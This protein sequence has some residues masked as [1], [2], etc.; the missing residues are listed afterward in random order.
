MLVTPPVA[1]RMMGVER[2]ERLGAL[3]LGSIVV[4]PL[5]FVFVWEDVFAG[6]KLFALVLV[7]GGC[8]IAVVTKRRA[9]ERALTLVPSV[10]VPLTLLLAL[11]TAA[12][13]L[14]VDLVQS[15]LGERLQ[16]QGYLAF[17][18]YVAFFLVARVSLSTLRRLQV[19]YLTVASVA[20]IVA[21]YAI[22]QRLG[23]DPVWT[24][25]PDGRVFSTIGQPNALGAFFVMTVPLTLAAAPRAAGT[26]TR[27]LLGAAVAGQLL[28]LLLTASRAALV[29]L[30]AALV[31]LAPV[32]WRWRRHHGH[33]ASVGLIAAL[34]VCAAVVAW[35]A[36]SA[37]SL[38]VQRLGASID[39]ATP[40]SVRMHLDL[41]AVAVRVAADHPVFG[42]GPDTY[43]VVFPAYRDRVLPEQQ[44]DAFV[45]YRVESPHNV[46]L[47]TASGSGIPAALTYTWI[48]GVVIWL[49]LRARREGEHL[50]ERVMRYGL[51]AAIVGHFVTDVFMTAEVTSSWLF[52]IL[53]GGGVGFTTRKPPS[54]TD[55]P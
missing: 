29:G 6:P 54:A 23:L 24:S 3:L 52:W 26:R 40:G 13:V 30:A 31:V 50:P 41:W 10:D 45:G 42:T 35:P 48:V 38:L 49:L 34:V 1:T 33:R 11:Q 36:R 4:V 37:T 15:F 18:V 20:T 55:N 27:A 32:L 53:L 14:S 22:A 25:L 44:A 16:H 12:L 8:V 7:L 43:A 51:L 21:A 2:S 19:L 5:V 17:L 9:D 39:T 47:A 46:V 28:A